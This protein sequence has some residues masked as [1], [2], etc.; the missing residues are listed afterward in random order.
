ME[1]KNE[2][3]PNSMMKTQSSWSNIYSNYDPTTIS[4]ETTSRRSTGEFILTLKGN[5]FQ[6]S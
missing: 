4:P 1:D 5:N 6:V 3:N 2:G